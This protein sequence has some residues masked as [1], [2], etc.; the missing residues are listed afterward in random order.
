MSR[1]AAMG[2]PWL[3]FELLSEHE[4]TLISVGSGFALV[5][6]MHTCLHRPRLPVLP[7]AA[8]QDRKMLA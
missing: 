8:A 1:V 3:R 4:T 6:F 2:G 7:L 5:V